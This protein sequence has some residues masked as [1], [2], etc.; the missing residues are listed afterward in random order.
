MSVITLQDYKS[1]TGIANPADDTQLGYIISYVNAFIERYCNTKFSPTTVVDRFLTTT[2]REVII[3]E[4]P[5]ISI[6]YFST[7]TGGGVYAETSYYHAEL[8]L[9]IVI[10]APNVGVPLGQNNIR[11]SYTYGYSEAPVGVVLPALELVSYLYKREYIKSKNNSLGESVTY[12]DPSVV[13]VHVRAGL[14]L[15]RML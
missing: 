9:G 12:L 3:P 15:Y 11:V 5:L 1:Y 2:T 10:I 4:A 8:E 6:D 14:D 7:D 13:P